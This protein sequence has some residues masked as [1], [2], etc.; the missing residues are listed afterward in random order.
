MTLATAILL[1]VPLI[2][3]LMV[4]CDGPH[5]GIKFAVTWFLA[6]HLYSSTGRT[7][8]LSLCTISS[9]CQQHSGGTAT[10]II[11]KNFAT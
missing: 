3:F 10:V 5:S 9:R 2:I 11:L 1:S 6:I 7:I 4:Y 8:F